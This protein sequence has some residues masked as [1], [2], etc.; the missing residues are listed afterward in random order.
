M[1]QLEGSDDL[2]LVWL[3]MRQRWKDEEYFFYTQHIQPTL[4]QQQHLWPL[5]YGQCIQN[6]YT[7]NTCSNIIEKPKW[8][9]LDILKNTG[10]ILSVFAEHGFVLAD[11]IAFEKKSDMFKSISI[12]VQ[13][14][15]Q[16]RDQQALVYSTEKEANWALENY[17]NLSEGVAIGLNWYDESSGGF[18]GVTEHFLRVQSFRQQRWCCYFDV[19][20]STIA[21]FVAILDSWLHQDA[22]WCQM[23]QKFHSRDGCSVDLEDENYGS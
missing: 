10:K 3:A 4:Q 13:D 18:I 5:L 9:S 21:N 16:F 6:M 8:P 19:T 12:T 22:S 17:F 15:T 2:T 7:R 14:F 20:P 11:N 1:T 23:S